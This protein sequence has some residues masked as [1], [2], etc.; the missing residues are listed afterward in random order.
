MSFSKGRRTA[1]VPYEV[2]G[3]EVAKMQVDALK[4]NSYYSIELFKGH[5]ILLMSKYLFQWHKKSNGSL[6]FARE[7]FSCYLPQALIPEKI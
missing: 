5:L 1:F 6:N 4:S 2:G 7:Q 3:E